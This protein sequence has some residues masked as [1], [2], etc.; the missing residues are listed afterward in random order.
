MKLP[1]EIEKG[2]P[3]WKKRR[4]ELL[5]MSVMGKATKPNTG[6]DVYQKIRKF[7]GMTGDEVCQLMYGLVVDGFLRIKG[8]DDDC[9]YF[10]CLP[11]SKR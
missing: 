4:R 11:D 10:Y 7:N 8:I 3:Y 1:A 5:V 2:K 9:G 6:W